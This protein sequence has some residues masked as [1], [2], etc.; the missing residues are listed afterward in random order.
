M[1]KL[2]DNRARKHH[3]C[4]AKSDPSCAKSSDLRVEAKPSSEWRRSDSEYFDAVAC[5]AVCFL[6]S[7]TGDVATAVVKDP[8]SRG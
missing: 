7:V 1:M 3:R 4:K 6:L 5:L 8:H 2:D